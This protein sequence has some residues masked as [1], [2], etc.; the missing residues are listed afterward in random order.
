MRTYPFQDL[1]VGYPIWYPNMAIETK[2]VKFVFNFNQFKFKLKKLILC[3][4]IG[5][6]LSIF[7]TTRINEYA[8]STVNFMISKYRSTIS[9]EKLASLQRQAAAAAAA[10]PLQSCPTPCDPIDGSPPGSAVPGIF[11]A[12]VLEWGAIAFSN[13]DML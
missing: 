5:R 4:V 2:G 6:I 12:R 11:Q 1:Q 3:S 9:S 10:K 13:R 7:G 8:F